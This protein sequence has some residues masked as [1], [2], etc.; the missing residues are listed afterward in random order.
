M[1]KQRRPATGTDEEVAASLDAHVELLP[2]LA[3]LLA[4]VPVLGANL[5][6]I[7]ELLRDHNLAA[8]ARVLDLA[9]GKG[10]VALRLA[11]ELRLE[12]LGVDL[13]RPFVEEARRRAEEVGVADRCTFEVQDLRLAIE[14]AE[15]YDVAVYASVG[16]LGELGTAV[17]ALRTAV[18]A[19]GWI[20]IDDGYLTDPGLVARAGYE[21]YMPYEE[22]RR[23]LESAGDRVLAEMVI[24]LSEIERANRRNTAAIHRRAEDLARRT[25]ENRELFLSYVG[26]QE[27]EC[28]ALEAG[29]VNAVWLVERAP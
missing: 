3:D 2:Y 19:D 17:A 13:F 1:G 9:C 24:P 22:T 14:A 8:G 5:E 18:R 27:E 4:D 20:V 21:H 11:T 23:R 6:V 7:V 10:A 25:P 15:G 16:A 28:E 12:V 26:R 29:F